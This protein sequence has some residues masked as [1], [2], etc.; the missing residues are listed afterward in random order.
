MEDVAV[1]QAEL[2]LQIERA[3]GSCRAITLALK[4]GA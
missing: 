2:A 1:G 3:T 4:P